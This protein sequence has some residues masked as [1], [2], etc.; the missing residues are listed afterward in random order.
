MILTCES[1]LH[2][3]EYYQEYIFFELFHARKSLIKELNDSFLNELIQKYL[4]SS[5]F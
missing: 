1:F 4:N 3:I 2:L 5:Y